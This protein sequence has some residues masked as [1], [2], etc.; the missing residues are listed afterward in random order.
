[1]GQHVSGDDKQ[2]LTSTRLPI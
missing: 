2:P 1:V